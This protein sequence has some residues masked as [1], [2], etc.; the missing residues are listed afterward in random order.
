MSNF[1]LADY[2]GL[3]QNMETFANWLLEMQ[4]RF[5]QAGIEKKKWSHILKIKMVRREIFQCIYHH[6][7]CKEN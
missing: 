4:R 6:I 2:S 5:R 7:S 1:L 3:W